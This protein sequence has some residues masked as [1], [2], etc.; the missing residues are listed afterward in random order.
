MLQ[1]RRGVF[2]ANSSSTH[3]VT[4]MEKEKYTKWDLGIYYYNY[5]SDSFE[6]IDEIIK[7]YERDTNKKFKSIEDNNFQYYLNDNQ[8]YSIDDFFDKFETA[9][10]HYTTKSGDEIVAVSIYDYN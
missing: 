10:E 1:I 2:E 4:I 7:K 6:T 5:D 9:T 3:S 8:I